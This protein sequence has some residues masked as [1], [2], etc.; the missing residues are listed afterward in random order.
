MQP[1]TLSPSDAQ[2]LVPALAS[3]GAP[4][5]WVYRCHDEGTGWTLSVATHAEPGSGK[6]SLG[7][8]RIAP[9]TRVASPGFSTEREAIQLAMGMEEKVRWSRTIGAGGPLA[10]RDLSR[11][12]GGKCVIAPTDDAR[13]GEPRDAE[14]LDFSI[15]CFR[16]IEGAGGF[17]IATGQDLGHGT[18]H[19]GTTGSLHYLHERFAGSA[20]A[21][22]S[23]PTGEGNVRLLTGMLRALEVDLARATVGL[24]GC[25]HVGMHVFGRLQALGT[26]LL[27]L[28]GWDVRRDELRAL[29]VPVWAL[30]EKEAFLS[31]PMDAVVVNAASGSLDGEAIDAICANGRLSVVCGSENL[32][33]PEPHLAFLL[34]DNE[35]VYAPTEFGGM[36]GYLTAA[37]E[38]LA[39]E[40]GQTFDASTLL[41]AAG[42]LEEV[43]YEATSQVRRGGFTNTF[44]AAVLEGGVPS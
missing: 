36:M 11:I 5:V 33:M 40:A 12:V 3:S 35:K 31:Q 20:I 25:G 41:A 17:R 15:A 32:A 42:R 24:L 19:D 23:V 1:T 6:L 38:Y 39:R 26:K 22:T 16:A 30:E 14:L 21:D 28:D 34:R 8:F 13:V 7:G 4:G 27:V 9:A 2:R 44:E 18:M 43:G 29:G 37:E 10:R